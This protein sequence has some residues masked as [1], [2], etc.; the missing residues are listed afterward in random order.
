MKIPKTWNLAK[1]YAILLM[2]KIEINRINPRM[3]IFLMLRMPQEKVPA[4]LQ[5]QDHG[6]LVHGLHALHPGRPPRVRRLPLRQEDGGE[7]EEEARV[8]KIIFYY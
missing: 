2:R 4:F 8:S 3:T 7:K 1:L 5:H 6:L